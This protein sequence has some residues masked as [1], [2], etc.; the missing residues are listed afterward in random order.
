[1]T[2]RI[3]PAILRAQIAALLAE[4]PELAEDEELRLSALEGQTDTFELLAAVVAE[5]RDAQTMRAAIEERIA[6]LVLRAHRFERREQF[7]RAFAQ[8]IMNAVELRKA[9]L[10]EAT[11]SVRPAPQSVRVIQPDFIPEQFWRVKREPDL[12]AI[13]TALKSGGDVPGAALSNAADVLA[14]ISK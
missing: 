13:K 4:H 7:H 11:L 9:T 10:P 2:P 14:I 3:D 5:I 6:T 8:R 12:S 1:M